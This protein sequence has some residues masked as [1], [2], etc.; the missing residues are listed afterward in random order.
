MLYLPL[1]YIFI[2][3][4]VFSSFLYFS[5]MIKKNKSTENVHDFIFETFILKQKKLP[6]IV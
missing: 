6:R 5:Q 4:K 1:I 2:C 3:Y